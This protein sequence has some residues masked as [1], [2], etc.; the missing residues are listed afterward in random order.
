MEMR[1]FKYFLGYLDNNLKSRP[2]AVK[3]VKISLIFL[4]IFSFSTSLYAQIY[5]YLFQNP[6]VDSHII[7]TH[8]SHIKLPDFSHSLNRIR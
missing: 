5:A 7:L 8:N 1:K 4:F 2:N 3:F 6:L